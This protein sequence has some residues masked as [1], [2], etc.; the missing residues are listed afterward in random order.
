[1]KNPALAATLRRVAAEGKAAFYEGAIAADV[2]ETARAAGG[3]LTARDLARL[4]GDRARAAPR[5]VGGLRRLHDAAASPAG[6]LMLIETL[7]MHPRAALVGAR[8]GQRE[9]PA[10]A[11]RDVPRRGRRSR[12]SPS[13]TRT[14]SR[15]TPR[16]WPPRRGCAARRAQISLT[17]TRPAERFA[18]DEGG[19]SHT[20]GR[21]RA[22]RRRVDHELGERHVRRAARDEG[23]LRAQRRARRTSPRR[24]SSGGSAIRAGHGPNSP[25][26]GARPASSMTPTVVL[27]RRARRCSRSAARAG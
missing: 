5:G 22:G 6:G 8:R 26:G 7:R 18:L 2:V 25:R 16:R 14:T 23:R 9:L 11:R 27:S 3:H 19:T 21:R 24:R 15:P 20:R 4:Q 12:P 10:P 17:A 13:A 1:M